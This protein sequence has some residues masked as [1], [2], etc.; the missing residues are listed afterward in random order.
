M[1]R[2]MTGVARFERAG[3]VRRRYVVRWG[4]ALELHEE[5]SGPSTVVAYGDDARTL[6]VTLSAQDEARALA[7][8]GVAERY[9][10][11]REYL[12]LERNELTNVMDACDRE[13]VPYSFFSAGSGGDVQF[14]PP[15]PQATLGS[16]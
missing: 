6:R 5:L 14:R 3:D 16:R 10:S 12:A 1:Q 8:L 4:D 13:G 9:T 11:L 2:E 7:A 15:R